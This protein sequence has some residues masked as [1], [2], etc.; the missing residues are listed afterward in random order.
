M[1]CLMNSQILNS[2]YAAPMEPFLYRDLL[3]CYKHDAPT[4]QKQKELLFFLKRPEVNVELTLDQERALATKSM[5]HTT[6]PLYVA[7]SYP[8][9]LLSGGGN[10]YRG[11]R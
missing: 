7:L 8:F 2:F 6:P 9:H 1:G 3:I 10:L 11:Q 5:P 4:E